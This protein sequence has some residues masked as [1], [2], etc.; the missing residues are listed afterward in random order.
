[1]DGLVTKAYENWMHVME[2]DGKS[3]LKQQKSPDV[4]LPE[5]P[6]ASQDYPNSF[7]QQFT[8]PSLPASVSSEPPTMDSGLNVGGISCDKIIISNDFL[9]KYN[10]QPPGPKPGGHYTQIRIFGACIILLIVTATNLKICD[11]RKWLVCFG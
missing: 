11:F 9:T 2:Y 7:D 5:V 1:M 6:I 10:P 3:L 8:L 4:S